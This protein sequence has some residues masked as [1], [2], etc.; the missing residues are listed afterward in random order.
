MSRSVG[1]IC[2]KYSVCDKATALNAVNHRGL[3]H[4]H[5]HTHIH[6]KQQRFEAS[7]SQ[8]LR[9]KANVWEWQKTEQSVINHNINTSNNSLWKIKRNLK[10]IKR[11]REQLSEKYPEHSVLERR[12][13]AL[14]F[15]WTA[16]AWG[17]GLKWVIT[18][19][20]HIYEPFFKPS[21]RTINL[22][23]FSFWCLSY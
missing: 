21:R 3:Q 12:H 10:K 14:K 13:L 19:N 2:W 9:T 5:K 18:T 6:I 4:T 22:H 17:F 20:P 1:G 15:T 8:S 23:R 16:G 11:R 7:E